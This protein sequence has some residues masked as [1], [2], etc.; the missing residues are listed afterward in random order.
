MGSQLG[1]RA[2]RLFRSVSQNSCSPPGVARAVRRLGT[3]HTV[4]LILLVLAVLWVVAAAAVCL[5]PEAFAAGGA[6]VFYGLAAFLGT[7]VAATMPLVALAVAALTSARLSER[8]DAMALASF[9]LGPRASWRMLWPLWL[10]L[11]LLTLL[12]AFVVEPPAWRAV[13]L[14]KGAPEAAAV[15]WSRL[16]AGEVRVLPGGG[17]LVLRDSE[18]HFAAGDGL[19]S[20]S[21]DAATVL[22]DERDWGWSLG[23]S[24]A[25][26]GDGSSWRAEKLR[27]LP[28]PGWLA[29][30]Q[31]PPRSPWSQAPAGLLAGSCGFVEAGEACERSSFVLHRRLALAS[32]VPMM[33][34][35]GWLLAWE[36]GYGGR[37]RSGRK[38]ALLTLAV[39]LY[40]LL[41]LGE[42]AVAMGLLGGALGAWLPALPVF[43]LACWMSF[44]V[45]GGAR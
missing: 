39:G 26:G 10:S 9:G 44:K 7:V 23:S 11:A 5:R 24:V 2:I 41:K 15:A 17:A 20:G 40:A 36:L 13:H 18:L 4:S 21:F 22:M 37:R 19:W 28:D 33:A 43:L 3:A 16:Q 34:L 12:L 14:L 32:L 35:V 38:L 1:Y 27:L 45:R 42:K 25:R 30:Y 6:R 8:G 29:R 31:S